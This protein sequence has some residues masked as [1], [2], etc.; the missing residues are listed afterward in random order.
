M[1]ENVSLSKENYQNHVNYKKNFEKIWQFLNYI[2]L[3]MTQTNSNLEN[4]QLVWLV[5]F[6]LNHLNT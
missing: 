5:R 4:F 1:I 2:K 3:H 6:L